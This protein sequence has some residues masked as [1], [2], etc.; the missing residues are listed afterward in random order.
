MSEN[1]DTRVLVSGASGL[2]GRALIRHLTDR[3]Y[4]VRTLVRHAPRLGEVSWDP[5]MGLLDPG[6][7]TGVQAVVH[8]AGENIG[9]RWTSARKAR[10][11][12]SRLQGTRLLSE[13]L[14]SLRPPP[15]VMVSASAVGVY[16][17]RGD[18]ILTEESQP[19]DRLDFLA[20]L[21]QD[22]EAAAEP[23]R[24]AGIRVVHPRFGL[25]LSREGGALAKMLPPFRLGL[26][27]RLGTG[28]QW[29]SW[30]AMDD[31]VA[32]V[33]HL[34]RAETL[35]G[36]VNVTSPEPSRNADFTRTLG[37]VLRRPTAFAVPSAA[38]HL[39]FGEMAD[40]TLLASTR[41]LPNRLV[42]SG[43]SFEYPGLE[44][45]LRHVLR[46]GA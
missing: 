6:Q 3:G 26:G 24:Q 32:A 42:S 44:P 36:A 14:A 28:L 2:I 20:A 27:G 45:A 34:I 37:D 12:S 10:I 17:S 38:L 22:W 43:F 40:A 41:V 5:A 9:A 4:Q 31:L 21:V 16:G 35:H 23:A 25:A 13:A 39:A 18:E 8:L 19:G 1:N 15:G 30:I 29:M 11:R 7:L 46:S 33:L